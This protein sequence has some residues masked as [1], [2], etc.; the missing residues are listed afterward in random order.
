[1]MALVAGG[2]GCNAGWAAAFERPTLFQSKLD[3]NKLDNEHFLGSST[4]ESM[5]DDTGGRSP[6]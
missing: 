3:Q 1:M 4:R 6:Q 2:Y 5:K